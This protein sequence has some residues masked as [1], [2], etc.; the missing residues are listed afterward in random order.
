ML[1]EK[2]TSRVVWLT[3]AACLYF[4][5]S[6]FALSGQAYLNKFLRYTEWCQHLPKSVD[7]EFLAFIHEPTPLNLKLREKWL[8]QLAYNKDWITFSQ[9][10]LG[11][12]DTNLQCYAL[13]ALYN[14]GLHERA[15]LASKTLWLNGGSQPTACNTLFTALLDNNEI[16]ESLIQQRL[17]LALENN[18]L[19]LAR[20]LLKQYKPA[21]IKDINTLT[22]IFQTPKRI[23]QLTPGPL[24]G[25]FYLYGLKL[26]IPH[27]IHQAIQ[28]FESPQAQ[29]IM[30]EDQ[31]QTFLASVA[32][33]KAINN[34]PDTE[35]WFARVKRPWYNEVLLE[36]EVR[37]ALKHHHWHKI[38]YLISQSQNKHEPNY[39]YWM[40]R[41]L[42]ALGE[43]QTANEIYQK[44]AKKRNYYGFLASLKLKKRPSFEN[45]AITSDTQKLA[46]YK[47]IT[48]QIKDLYLSRKTLEASRLLNDF[49]S[50]LPKNEKSALAWWVA[51]DLNWHDKSIYLSTN[52][53]LN[54]QLTLRFPLAHRDAV[55]TYA[56]QYQVPQELI[57]AIIRQE[58]SFHY[59]I[60]SSAGANGLMQVMHGTA[61]VVA[62]RANIFYTNK[63]QLFSPKKNINIGTAYLQQL[64]RQYHQHP[65]LMIAA[66]NAGPR[67]VNY[68]LK[69]HAPKEID[70]WIETL[71]WR[72]TRNYLKNIIAYY[73]VYQ[74][75]MHERASLD[76][77]MEPF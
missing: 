63:T 74:Y 49:I 55:R 8:Y 35:R 32:L 3:F 31:R 40:A 69:N 10:Y 76:A 60:V 12:K 51:N 56:K 15:M 71:P 26:M 64:A 4:T 29:K 22:T 9:Y 62:K 23:T 54:N 25:S 53:D 34:E 36:W 16:S 52:D 43:H 66:Y 21:R 24:Q 5:T 61:D 47:P 33:D 41:A 14:Q 45:E 75:R 67:Q 27:N 30:N 77:F 46:P 1:N 13:T 18:N 19:S 44:V 42:A 17:E 65:V 72:E 39:E 6:A 58:S 57:Y 59:D 73:S 48:D 68:W 11:S 2:T 70:I 50:E 37:Y 38:I 20:Y 7:P 28:L